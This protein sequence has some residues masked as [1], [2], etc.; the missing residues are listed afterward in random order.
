MWNRT[1]IY[2][3]IILH[4][5][6]V[7]NSILTPAYVYKFI[8]ILWNKPGYH[9][10]YHTFEIIQLIKTLG[11]HKILLTNRCTHYYYYFNAYTSYILICPSSDAV[12]RSL[13]SGEKHKPRIGMAWPGMWLNSEMVWGLKNE[14][15]KKCNIIWR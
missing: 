2:E 4:R 5:Q 3:I 9:Q 12:T 13:E 10:N 11:K 15:S 8:R 14:Y 7:I 6:S 1:N